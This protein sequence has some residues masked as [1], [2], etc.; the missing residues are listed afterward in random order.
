[1]GPF[2]FSAG[3]RAGEWPVTVAAADSCGY[4]ALP[5]VTPLPGHRPYRMMSRVLHLA[6]PTILPA[7]P[8]GTVSLVLQEG[9]LKDL[10]APSWTR[11]PDAV[12]EP[13][14]LS[15]GVVFCV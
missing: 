6:Q 8:F 1:M 2:H 12:F 15:R 14:R 10:V 7:S 11:L 5:G 4:P 9:H 13:A 3:G